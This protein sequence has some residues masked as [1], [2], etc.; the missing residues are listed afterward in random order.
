MN[1]LTY[2]LTARLDALSKARLD[3]LKLYFKSQLGI[4]MSQSQLLRLAVLRL[5]ESVAQDIESAREGDF[6]KG[7]RKQEALKTKEDNYPIWKSGALPEMPDPFPTW[8]E[9][10]EYIYP[11]ES[12]FRDTQKT[13]LAPM[14][15]T[16]EVDPV[17]SELKSLFNQ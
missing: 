16:V 17:A 2:S 15:H 3:Y 8:S 12:R 9:L 6:S 13:I 7:W 4:S 1:K 14:G 10:E 11:K 5:V